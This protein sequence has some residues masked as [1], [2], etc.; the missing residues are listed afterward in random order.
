MHQAGSVVRAVA[1]T[2]VGVGYAGLL[3]MWVDWT[4]LRAA[5][6]ILY[7]ALIA[8]TLILMGVHRWGSHISSIRQVLLCWMVL[9]ALF[10][11]ALH[12]NEFTFPFARWSMYSTASPS[13]D[14]VWHRAEFQ[15]GASGH[16]PFHA[17]APSRSSRAFASRF[18]D[19]ANL[20]PAQDESG[21]GYA[22]LMRELMGT[23]NRLN[24][25][26]PI[27]SVSAYHCE[28]GEDIT[29]RGGIACELLTTVPSA[30]VLGE[31]GEP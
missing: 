31:R 24:P 13:R 30:V 25:D 7:A 2:A 19:L 9:S 28:L 6:F 1:I 22:D 14:F 4:P 12:W 23:H 17:V 20:H 10:A 5:E 15:S 8:T 29:D 27:V 11:Q 3:A 21:R 16:F 18:S 26:D